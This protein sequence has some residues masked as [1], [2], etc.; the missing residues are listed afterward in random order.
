MNAIFGVGAYS[1]AEAGRLLHVSPTT[2]RRWAFGYR[3]SPHGRPEGRQPPLWTPQYPTDRDEPV[4]GFRDLIEARIVRNL[5][6]IGLGLPT[7]RRCLATAAEVAQDNHPFSTRRFKTDGKRLYLETIRDDGDSNV[8]DLKSR[9]HAFVRVIES[10]F[11]DLDFEHD[12]AARWWLTAKHSLVI[13]PERGFGQPITAEH[14]IPTIR[15]LEATKAEGSPQ[16]VARLFEIP[17]SVVKDAVRF[18]EGLRR[19]A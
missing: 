6:K 7:I 13:D 17:V 4:I 16:A 3:Y 8:I 14:G 12:T 1:P 18:E 9:Q 15:L 19:A 11:L 2:I 10:T 5:R